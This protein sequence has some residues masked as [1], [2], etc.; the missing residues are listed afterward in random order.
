MHYYLVTKRHEI[1]TDTG[2]ATTLHCLKA[3]WEHNIKTGQRK[4]RRKYK[5]GGRFFWSH[6]NKAIIFKIQREV[7]SSWWFLS[8]FLSF[9]L[10]TATHD[11]RLATA[12]GLRPAC[13]L[14]LTWSLG[15]TWEYAG[16]PP[17]L[18]PRGATAKELWGQ[19]P[20][21]LQGSPPAVILQT[22]LH[23]T[24]T[25]SLS[26]FF[27]SN[28]SHME[29]ATQHRADTQDGFLLN[30]ETRIRINHIFVG[31]GV[32]PAHSSQYQ[33]GLGS[34]HHLPAPGRGLACSRSSL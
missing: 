11:F 27:T 13:A 1:V 3:E 32:S 14:I 8:S 30:E 15:H 34:V 18:S 23:L 29:T 9:P 16:F 31:P 10:P 4:D 19:P 28:K 22:S 26:S 5:F 12:E 7:G 33:G 6:Q 17:D 20:C 25:S 2:T 21:L 24:P